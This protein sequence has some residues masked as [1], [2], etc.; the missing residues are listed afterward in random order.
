MWILCT[1]DVS[2]W[3]ITVRGIVFYCISLIRDI[4]DVRNRSLI[5]SAKHEAF[6]VNFSEVFT[7]VWDSHVI[8]MGVLL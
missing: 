5:K 7:K 3:F 6:V 4:C 1:Y 8:L 2:T